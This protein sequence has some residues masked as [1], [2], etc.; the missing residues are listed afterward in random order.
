MPPPGASSLGRSSFSAP[1]ASSIGGMKRAPQSVHG[2]MSFDSANSKYVAAPNAAVARPDTQWGLEIGDLLLVSRD[3]AKY[4]TVDMQTPAMINTM[5]SN[6]TASIDK[7]DAN[8]PKFAKLVSF[9]RVL[10]TASEDQLDFVRAM[11]E[12][13]PSGAWA[14]KYTDGDGKFDNGLTLGDYRAAAKLAMDRRLKATTTAGLLDAYGFAGCVIS[15]SDPQQTGPVDT[16]RYSRALTVGATRFGDSHCYNVWGDG[17]GVN[18]ELY[19][20]LKRRG[21]TDAGAK[22]SP[23]QYVPA[24][25]RDGSPAL[26]DMLYRDRSGA[27][28]IAHTVYVGTV[29]KV[30]RIHNYQEEARLQS[31]GLL[32]GNPKEQ[33]ESIVRLGTVRV[34]V[35]M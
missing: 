12:K 2:W 28:R 20:V 23:Y 14:D 10:E 3:Y 4:F 5:L 7:V 33:R 6:A 25:S 29:N 15:K 26:G 22:N 19:L 9:R 35:A 34:E 17:I 31:V 27:L 8:E 1:G 30:N 32:S 13:D 16:I 18:D 11:D 24:A 21:G